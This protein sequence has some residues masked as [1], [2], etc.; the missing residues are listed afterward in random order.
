MWFLYAGVTLAAT[1]QAKGALEDENDELADQS[2]S[3]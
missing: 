1:I 3:F 2:Q